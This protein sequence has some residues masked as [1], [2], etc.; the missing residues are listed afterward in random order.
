MRKPAQRDN[1]GRDRSRELLNESRQKCEKENLWREIRE[2]RDMKKEY[3]NKSFLYK[4]SFKFSMFCMQQL[5]GSITNN[6]YFYYF[7][8]QSWIEW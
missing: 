3:E 5:T 6:F 2:R 7:S 4:Q 8:S 1:G